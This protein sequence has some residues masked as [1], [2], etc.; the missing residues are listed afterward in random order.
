MLKMKIIIVCQA[1]LFTTL[2]LTTSARPTS[3]HFISGP[4]NSQL[5]P[6]E[7]ESL[8]SA[9]PPSD[10][11]LKQLEN[12]DLFEGDIII[13]PEEIELYYDKQNKTHVRLIT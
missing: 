9:I 2:I 13:S 7:V 11:D 10:E 8:N 12:P 3:P 5:D 1:L 4:N 6:S